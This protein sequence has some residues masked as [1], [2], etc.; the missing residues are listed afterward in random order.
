MKTVNVPVL[1]DTLDE[2]DEETLFLNLTA[3]MNATIFDNLGD[4]RIVDDDNAAIQSLDVVLLFDD[5][6]SFSA[7]GPAVQAAF[8]S[9]ITQLQTNFPGASLAFGVSRFENY[10][11][12]SSGL[13][14]ILNQPLITTTTPQFQIAIDA[15]WPASPLAV[16]SVKSRSSRLCTRF[17]PVSDWMGTETATLRI[18]V[19][20]VW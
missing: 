17:P 5:T 1:G 7:V 6:L 11:T 20:L 12:N 9:V 13:P 16:A 10:S 19:R 2:S 3:A 15:R 4:G 14:F 18:P 8:A